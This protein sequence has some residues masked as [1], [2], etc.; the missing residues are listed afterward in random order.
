MDR[1]KCEIERVTY[2]NADSGWAVMKVTAQGYNVPV[3]L[4]GALADVAPGATLEVEGEWRVDPRFGRQFVASG[5]QEVMPATTE[6]LVRYLGSGMLYGVGPHFARLIVERFG[7]ETLQVLDNDIGRLLEIPNIGK[8][9]LDRIASGWERQKGVRCVSL[10]LQQ[11][12]VS[13]TYAAKI[14]GVYGDDTVARVKSDPYRLADEVWG[15]GFRY[16]DGIA[17]SL[18][19][20]KDDPRRLRSG[21]LHTLTRMAES[22]GDVYLERDQLTAYA[23]TLLGVDGDAVSTALEAAVSGNDVIADGSAIYLPYYYHAEWGSA[24]RLLA[25]VATECDMTGDEAGEYINKVVAQSQR[26][27]VEYDEAQIDAVRMALTHHVMVLTGGPGTGKTTTTRAIIDAF[28]AAGR[29]I[30]LAAP[31][32]RAAKRMAEATGMEAVTLHRLLEYSPAGGYGRDEDNPLDGEVLIVDECS[33]IDLMLFY[34]VLRALPEGMRLVMVGDIDQLPSVGAGN[35]LRDIIASEVVPV[36]CLSRIFR[37]AQTSR[38]I[39]NAHAINHGRMPDMSN[40][41]DTDFFFINVA[42]TSKLADTVCALVA[43]RLPKAYGVHPKEIQVLTPMH[44]GDAGAIALNMLLQER[45]TPGSGGVEGGGRVYRRGDKVMQIRNNYDKNVFNG[46]IGFVTE[47]DCKSRTLT[48]DF[49]GNRVEYES[50]DLDE[51]T[52]AYGVTIHKSQGCEF[53]VVVIVVTR[54]HAVMLQRNLLYTAITRARKICVLVGD[55]AGV[56]MAVDN[57]CASSRHSRLA[58]R[59]RG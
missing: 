57:A 5:W 14:Y 56:S 46:D 59:L 52:L 1:L 37:Q 28:T 42:D 18:G 27:G 35:V 3:T 40:G 54:R 33:M 44:K 20:V 31:T 12:G 36:T 25:M 50:S 6:G 48:V 4:V 9:K 21:L 2:A 32:G 8:K 49:D 47:I 13:A 45:L 38:I 15:I 24:R 7:M 11:H 19:Y 39:M 23:A 53:E 26:K 34:R 51:L 55:M 10:F 41:R 17:A 16:A 29:K 43:D 30:R 58:D 22:E